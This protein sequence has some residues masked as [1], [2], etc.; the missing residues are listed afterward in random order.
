MNGIIKQSLGYFKKNKANTVI[1]CILTFLTSFMYFF[2]QCSIDANKK[3]LSRKSVTDEYDEMFRTAL[4][5]NSVLSMTFLVCLLLITLFI[6][7][8]FYKKKFEL[9]RKNMGLLRS[10]GFTS[11]SI[12]KVYMII[13]FAIGMIFSLAGMG[14]GYYFS[15]ILL[16]NYKISCHIDHAERGL[17]F[18]SFFMGVILVSGVISLGALIASRVYRSEEPSVLLSGQTKEMENGFINRTAEKVS[19]VI[20]SKYSFSSRL[21][22]RKPFNILLMLIS[23][24][25]YLVLILV[26]FSLNL[27]SSKIYSSLTAGRDFGYEIRFEHISADKQEDCEYFRT[28]KAVFFN[29]KTEI[30]ELELTALNNGGKA[31]VLRCGDDD[32]SLDDRE[33][34]V[35]LRTSEV[36]GVKAGDELSA[37]YDGKEYTFKVKAVA[38]NASMDSVYV[39]LGYWDRLNGDD[40]EAYNGIWCHEL[41]ENTDGMKVLS[42]DDY[43]KQLDDA[44]VSNRISAVID[45]VLGCV[46]GLLLIFL[47]L[48]LNFQD[49]SLNFIYL[50]KL[51]Y[52]R[53]EIR[54]MLVNI[55]FPIM[56]A[57][58]II[59][60]IPAVFTSK[61]ILRMLSL[62]TGDYMPFV[63][64]LPVFIYAFIILLVLYF[65]VLFMFDIKLK[66]MLIKIDNGEV[67]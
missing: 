14:T 16:E 55:Y 41:P 21:A 4:E 43:L 22:L 6:F 46:F 27:S 61:A 42:Y 51:G 20:V 10:L 40:P 65:A 58:F 9:E 50:R 30:G 13:S 32:V 31:F 36:F 35:S 12:T 5:S 15:Y 37:E 64:S 24:F 59:S 28:D 66:K 39:N 3:V 62:Q 63:F 48:L 54:K 11:N 1:L 29:G 56:I 33:A 19:K 34:A 17:A 44:N 26:S 2:V 23:V 8:M 53:H 7:Y 47:V 18:S 52:L 38:D 45:Q 67:V 49:N 57:A 60:V 25:V